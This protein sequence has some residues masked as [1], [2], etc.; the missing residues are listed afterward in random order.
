MHIEESNDEPD[1]D[2]GITS[3][4]ALGGFLCDKDGQ[5][6]KI[7]ARQP[8]F[9]PPL[10]EGGSLL[11][12]FSQ[13]KDFTEK[14]SQLAGLGQSFSTDVVYVPPGSQPVRLRAGVSVYF[15]DV[16]K[17]GLI[18]AM[19]SE[20][21]RN[22]AET[23]SLVAQCHAIMDTAVDAIITINETGIIESINPATCRM[24]GYLKDELIG[25]NIS[26]LMPSPYSEEHDG[27]LKDYRRTG[28][29][30]IIG[31]GRR[32]SGMKRDGSQFP[33]HLAVTEFYIGKERY[34]S[35][36]IR[37]L[38][39][40]ETVHQQLLQSARLAAIGQMVT[41]LAHESRNALQRAQACLDMLELELED[42]PDLRGLAKRATV[43]LQDLHRLYEE[44][45]S[46]A[47]PIHLEIREC[48]ISNIWQK[49][50]SNLA[51]VRSGLGIKLVVE[52]NCTHA[53]CEVD[54]HRMEQVFRNVLENAIHACGDSGTVQIT[55]SPTVL[56]EVPA[57][58]IVVADDGV[59]LSTTAAEKI[60][61]PFFTTKQKGTGLGMAIVRRILDAHSG[62]ITAAPVESG[63][64][65]VTIVLPVKAAI[66]NTFRTVPE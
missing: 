47:A 32:V 24:F 38:T 11:C 12:C 54:V 29:A 39:E 6:L 55:C 16:P 15:G 1:V 46:Y 35:G 21:E 14:W 61:E 9:W 50:W 52:Q 4:H 56:N 23:K 41:G 64:T 57:I 18:L 30:A 33:A 49:E 37:D 19:F 58:R 53:I 22:A 42:Q 34:F 63:G 59:G 44:V 66:R 5:I 28:R 51:A 17:S 62:V 31:V 40:L 45:R 60:F 65:H 7:I 3:E 13:D 26:K 27:Y 36:I 48:D 43:A 20:G 2:Y 10:K 8:G 25:A